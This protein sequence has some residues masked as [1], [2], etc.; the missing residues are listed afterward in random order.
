MFISCRNIYG[1]DKMSIGLLFPIMEIVVD[2]S[3]RVVFL[4]YRK[5]RK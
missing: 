5:K 4:E 3:D 2:N 1:D